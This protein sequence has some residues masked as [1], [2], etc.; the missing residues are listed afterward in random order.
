MIVHYSGSLKPNMQ[1]CIG[2]G[3]PQFIANAALEHNQY[4]RDRVQYLKDDQLH[5][6][7][8]AINQLY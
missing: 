7:V 2:A 3:E 6:R 1:P 5:F 8:A 4:Q